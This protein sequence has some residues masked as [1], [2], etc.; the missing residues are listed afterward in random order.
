MPVLASKATGVGRSPALIIVDAVLGFTSIDSP[1]GADFSDQIKVIDRLVQH[2]R[3]KGWPV[4][5]STVVYHSDDQASVFREKLP[6]LNILVPGS[7]WVKLDPRL[8]R[9]KQG[10]L[11]EKQHA[12]CFF[13]TDLDKMLRNAGVDSVLIGGF[14]TSGCVRATAVDALQYDYRVVVIEDASGDRD[15]VS[16]AANLKDLQLKYCDVSTIDFIISSY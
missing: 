11:L 9:G 4:I 10:I 7:K 2:A 12:S 8:S 16:H 3:K 6:D 1:L 5:F 15:P 14:T 13:G